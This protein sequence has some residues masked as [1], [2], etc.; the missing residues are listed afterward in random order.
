MWAEKGGGSSRGL[1]LVFPVSQ[2]PHGW[3]LPVWERD[4][5]EEKKKLMV[6]FDH[7]FRAGFIQ[8]GERQTVLVRSEWEWGMGG[9]GEK[10]APAKWSKL[11]M[12][13]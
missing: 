11:I 13:P 2:A 6:T 9:S 4:E 7:I 8:D 5:E 3:Q 1:L 12:V 10:V